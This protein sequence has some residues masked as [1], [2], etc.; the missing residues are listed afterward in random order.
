[1]KERKL[2]S[3]ILNSRI[4]IKETETAI[5]RGTIGTIPIVGTFI[6]EVLF[7]TKNRIYQSRINETVKI[8]NE[9]ISEID[10]SHINLEYLKSP[11]FFDFTNE[12]FNNILKARTKEKK[13]ALSKMY[14]ESFVKESQFETNK[15]RLFMNFVT[16]LTSVQINI[17]K[18]VEQNQDELMEIASYLK[19][20]EK[21][22]NFPGSYK[23]QRFEF[24]YYSNDLENKS[25]LSF[26]AGLSDD[27][28]TSQRLVSQSHHD[29]SAILTEFGKEFIY[30]LNN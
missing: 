11:D 21:Y 13:E 22:D 24:K 1:M 3:E 15:I 2:P 14:I 25:L 8:L 19:F 16:E 9:K 23:L 20:Q 28:D 17:L 26:G 30:F 7:E 12:L 6:N 29:P 4:E 10:N 5:L 27:F 18:F